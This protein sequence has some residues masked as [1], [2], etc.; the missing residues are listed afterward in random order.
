MVGYMAIPL[1]VPL[2]VHG[3]TDEWLNPQDWEFW[4][5]LLAVILMASVGY[6]VAL[7]ED[8]TPQPH[9]QRRRARLPASN[10]RRSSTH[11]PAIRSG[12]KSSQPIALSKGKGQPEHRSRPK[13]RSLAPQKSRASHQRS[14]RRSAKRPLPS[15]KKP[16]LPAQTQTNKKPPQAPGVTFHDS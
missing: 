2:I 10:K 12:A 5:M 3:P 11:T 7:Q 16:R 9:Q 14:S 4:A 1:A 6:L 8:Q 15:R 13:S